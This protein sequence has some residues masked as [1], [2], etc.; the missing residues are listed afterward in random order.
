MLSIKNL[1]TRR[2]SSTIP[3]GYALDPEDSGLLQPVEKEL[4]ALETILSMIKSKS[5]SLREGALWLSHKTGR[6]ISHE[7]LRKISQATDDRH[8]Q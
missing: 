8:N 7:G 5:L 4:E 1:K 2:S 6:T 3:F